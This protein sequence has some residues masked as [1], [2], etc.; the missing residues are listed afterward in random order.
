MKSTLRLVAGITGMVAVSVAFP[1]M[2]TTV[3]GYTAWYIR[4]SDPTFTEGGQ[5][6]NGQVH[7][8]L[9]GRTL[10]FTSEIGKTGILRTY[11]LGLSALNEV[12]SRVVEVGSPNGR[13]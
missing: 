2:Y 12:L 8:N 5:K 7:K 4:V 11:L 6:T 3:R 1:I 10:L 13:R 9:T